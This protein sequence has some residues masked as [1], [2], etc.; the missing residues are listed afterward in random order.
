MI[1]AAATALHPAGT[2]EITAR[3]TLSRY[4][5][6]EPHRDVCEGDRQAWQRKQAAAEPDAMTGQARAD[7]GA[8]RQVLAMPTARL[9]HVHRFCRERQFL[10]GPGIPAQLLPDHS[11]PGRTDLRQ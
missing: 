10:I 1:S 6:C 5:A 7:P 4:L 2:G 8:D 3:G 9:P 11:T